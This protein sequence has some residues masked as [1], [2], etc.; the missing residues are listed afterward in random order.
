VYSTCTILRRENEALVEAFLAEHPDF[1]LEPFTLPG[2]GTVTTGMKTLLPCVE[3][4]DGFFIAK[5]R[6]TDS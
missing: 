4:T 2:V 5:L 1:S 6:K 3:G